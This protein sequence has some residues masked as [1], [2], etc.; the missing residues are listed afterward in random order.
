M[1]YFMVEN[2]SVAQLSWATYLRKTDTMWPKLTGSFLSILNYRNPQRKCIE[3]T[4]AAILTVFHSSHSFKIKVDTAEHLYKILKWSP[5]TDY[6]WNQKTASNAKFSEQGIFQS[7]L[8]P[9]KTAEGILF[10]SSCTS[11]K[12]IGTCIFINEICLRG[13]LNKHHIFPFCC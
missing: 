2:C 9:P 13:C 8:S 11:V 5:F 4:N 3:G 6:K 12:T 1:K 7:S 10:C